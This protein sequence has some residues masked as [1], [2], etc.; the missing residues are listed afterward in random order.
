MPIHAPGSRVVIRDEEWLV[1]HADP[2]NDG[3]FQLTCDGLS[4]LVRGQSALFLTALE[5]PIDILDP[6]S[7]ELVPD[8]SR[9]Y[10]DSLLY[11]ESQRGRSTANDAA[12]HPGHREVMNL[13]PYQLDPAL[14]ELRQP[15]AR[16]LIADAVGPGQ[17]ARSRHPG[18]RAHPAR[19]WQAHPGGHAQ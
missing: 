8:T 11:L 17:D 2:S 6:A 12:L 13:V 5:E 19:P 18:H 10:N 16:L 15:R 3:G 7:T 14:Q 4:D 9:T 1:R